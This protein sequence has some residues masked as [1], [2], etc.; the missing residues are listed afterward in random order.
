MKLLRKLESHVLLELKALHEGSWKIGEFT[1]FSQ[2]LVM[3]IT[4]ELRSLLKFMLNAYLELQTIFIEVQQYIFQEGF[5]LSSSP[6][7]HRRGA[8][9]DMILPKVRWPQTEVLPIQAIW[10]RPSY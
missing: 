3:Q 5:G 2:H 7:L 10:H 9:Q 6:G 8:G 1:A 4:P